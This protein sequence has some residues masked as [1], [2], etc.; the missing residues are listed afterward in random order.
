MADPVSSFITGKQEEKAA[1][2][3]ANAQVE[4]AQA[5]I[6]ETQRQFDAM[7]EGLQPYTQ[8]GTQ[9][10]QA[11]QPYQQAGAGALGGLGQMA[12]YAPMAMQGQAAI[13]GLA[14]PEAQQQAISQIE[15]NPLYQSMVRQGE[16]AMMQNASATGGLRGGNFQAAMAQFRPQMLNELL[17]QQY[18]QYGGLAGMG[19]N[20]G[21]FL[22]SSG[23]NIGQNMM[24]IGQASAAGIGAAGMQAGAQIADL[25]GGQGSARAG[26]AMASA[27]PWQQANAAY[28]ST[29]SDAGNFFT[30]MYGGKA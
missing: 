18:A 12:S 24:Q 11:L 25:L 2:R 27:R 30:S 15:G 10:A 8:Y 21:Q 23:Q 7:R 4:S 29:L 3:A 17:N 1:K 26:A 6:S 28:Q 19:G 20:L 9:G 16:E 14:G 22:A 13:S 5:G